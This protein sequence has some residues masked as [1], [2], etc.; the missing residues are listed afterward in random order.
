MS[1]RS[2]VRV[3][4]SPRSIAEIASRYLKVAVD[5]GSGCSA[6]S[7]VVCFRGGVEE[8]GDWENFSRK[9]EHFS[10]SLT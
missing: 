9:R 4:D 8:V 10:S 6:S 3:E 1:S 2:I 5:W 7:I